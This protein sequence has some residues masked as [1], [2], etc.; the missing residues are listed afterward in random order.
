MVVAT[1]QGGCRSTAWHEIIGDPPFADA[2]L[3][4]I[5]HNSYR[6]VLDRQSMRK[7]LAESIDE[8][9]LN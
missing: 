9:D 2:I 3:D 7:T 4:R 6:L 1:G 8:N 5:A